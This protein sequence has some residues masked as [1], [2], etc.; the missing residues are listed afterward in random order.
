MAL[1]SVSEVEV[2]DTLRPTVSRHPSGTRDQFFFHPE[3]FF[4]QLRVCYFVALS[5]TRGRVCTLLLLLELA[6]AVPLWSESRGTQEHILLSKFLRLPQ[7]GGPGPRIY[8]P[9][10]QGGP[11]ISPGTGF[12]FRRLLR[13]VEQRW[14]YSIPPPHGS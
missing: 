7:H 1:L 2:E 8:I 12:L 4:R 13:L 10:E 9:Q 14:R 6:S 5:L 11:D 3:F